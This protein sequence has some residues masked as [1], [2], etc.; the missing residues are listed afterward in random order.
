M[1]QSYV[2]IAN[3]IKMY[4]LYKK[5]NENVALSV[6]SLDLHFFVIK[7]LCTINLK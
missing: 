6:F 5:K 1:I 7:M 2:I 4:Y 3:L